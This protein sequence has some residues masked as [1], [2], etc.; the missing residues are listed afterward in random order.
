[1]CFWRTPKKFLRSEMKNDFHIGSS[2]YYYYWKMLGQFTHFV[3]EEKMTKMWKPHS[4]V[5]NS[6]LKH[7]WRCWRLSESFTGLMSYFSATF[8]LH[9]RVICLQNFFY[10]NL[11]TEIC[12]QKFVYR[13][14]FT[15]IG[16][17][18]CEL[19]SWVFQATLLNFGV[20]M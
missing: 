15:E 11:F 1:M 19:H 4:I 8:I 7:L 14:W 13:N 9:S 18:T 5:T 17:H 6:C 20:Y 3:Q 12:L 10:S 16:L 2:Y